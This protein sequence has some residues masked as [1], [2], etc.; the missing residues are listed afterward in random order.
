MIIVAIE[1]KPIERKDL[2]IWLVVNILFIIGLICFLCLFLFAQ[3]MTYFLYFWFIMGIIYASISILVYFINPEIMYGMS[4]S[5]LSCKYK[6]NRG[7][8]IGK[9]L[10]IILFFIPIIVLIIITVIVGLV[11]II[12]LLLSI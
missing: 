3:L 8:N 10:Q 5:I 7:V 2:K 1:N 11:R 4:H 9:K 12:T 6:D